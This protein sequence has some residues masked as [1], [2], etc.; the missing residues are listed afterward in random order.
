MADIL[1]TDKSSNNRAR[2]ERGISLFAELLGYNPD[3]ISQT[4]GVKPN[5]FEG[6]SPLGW[7]YK[8][9]SGNIYVQPVI[10][11]NELDEWDDIGDPTATKAALENLVNGLRAEVLGKNYIAS[12]PGLLSDQGRAINMFPIKKDQFEAIEN[13]VAGSIYLIIEDEA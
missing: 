13:H 9:I 7:Y 10:W 4:P 11:D 6:G 1:K 3:Y 8:N 12:N 2:I 5:D